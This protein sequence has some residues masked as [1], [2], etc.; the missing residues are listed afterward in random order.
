LLNLLGLI[1]NIVYESL[2]EIGSSGYVPMPKIGEQLLG[3]HAVN[4]CGCFWEKDDIF[5][6]IEKNI[7]LFLNMPKYNGLYFIVRNSWGETF[8]DKGYMYI[9]AEFLQKYSFDW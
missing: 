8:G 5:N 4:I 7:D 2:E 9:P 6:K 3:G 1:E